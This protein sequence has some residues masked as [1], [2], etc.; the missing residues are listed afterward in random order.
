MQRYAQDPRWIIARRFGKCAKCG[1]AFNIGDRVFY[2]PN[3][4]RLYSGNCAETAARDFFAAAQD[5]GFY[6]G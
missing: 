6:C 4:K 2:Y 1:E 5:E 3:G